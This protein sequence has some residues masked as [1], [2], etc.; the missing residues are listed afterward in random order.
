M[1]FKMDLS[2]VEA[3]AE[4]AV[5]LLK[6]ISNDKRLLILCALH[7]GE[8]NVGELEHIVELSQSALSQHLARLR[9]DNLVVTRRDAQTVYYSLVNEDVKRVLWALYDIY[10]CPVEGVQ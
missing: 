1:D 5:S 10:G 4:S 6:A 2:V 9:H 3:K 7:R 8:R